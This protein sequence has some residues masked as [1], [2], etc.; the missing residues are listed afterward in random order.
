MKSMNKMGSKLSMALVIFSAL[1]MGAGCLDQEM[2]DESLDEADVA[3]TSSAVEAAAC[4]LHIGVTT[5]SSRIIQ[6]YGSQAGC[7]SDTKSYVQIERSRWN[8]WEPMATSMIVGPGHNVY[9]SYNCS[10]TGTHTF[11][12]KHMLNGYAS[13]YSNEIRVNCN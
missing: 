8:G 6:G 3:E 13:R 11:R 2:G 9:V 10:G 12:T 1:L 4:A 7:A 5:S